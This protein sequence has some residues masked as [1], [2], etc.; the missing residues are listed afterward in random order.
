MLAQGLAAMEPWQRYP[1]SASDLA[2]LFR[3]AND[4]T[5]RIVVRAR[6][7]TAAGIMIVRHPWLLGPYIVFLGLL[8]GHQRQGLG[9]ALLGFAEAE[10]RA[11]S[12]RNLWICVST[13]NTDAERLYRRFGFQPVAVLDDL[14]KDGFGELLMRKRLA[15]RA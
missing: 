14:V 1:T 13:F 12:A 2:S 7:Q 15:R 5:F 6:D 3:P 9:A 4:R 8:V 10:A 11:A